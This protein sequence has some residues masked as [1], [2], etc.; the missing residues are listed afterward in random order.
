MRYVR[1]NVR[2][3]ASSPAASAAQRA[4]VRAAQRI[5]R[6]GGPTWYGN[7]IAPAIAEVVAAGG[8][9]VSTVTS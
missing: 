8:S 7:Q 4:R 3:Y 2:R 1:A 6:S 9:A 5:A